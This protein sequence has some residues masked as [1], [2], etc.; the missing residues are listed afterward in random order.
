[1]TPKIRV[2]VIFGGTSTEHEVSLVSARSIIAALDPQK[3]SVLPVMITKDNRW[4]TPKAILADHTHVAYLPQT[5]EKGLT[6]KPQE[7]TAK[8]QIDVY[9]PVLH[10]PYGEDGTIQGLL[11]MMH[12]PYVGDG[13]LASA[14]CMDKD[15]QK[16]LCRE[17]GLPVIE[18]LAI[19]S[20]TEPIKINPPCFVKPANQG[21]SVG[22]TKVQ[23]QSELEAAIQQAFT[24]DTKVLIEKAVINPREIE[25]AVL[26]TTAKPEAS[27]LGE[28]ISSN[29]FYDYD[30]K[31]VDGKSK[32]IIPAKLTAKLTAAIQSAAKKAFTV[33]N[34]YGLARVDFLLDRAGEYYLS[35]LNTLPGFTTISMYPKLWAASGLSYPSLLDKLIELAIL[36]QHERA[37]LATTYTPKA[38]WYQPE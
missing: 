4:L 1:M 31:Y 15:I 26:G 20:P 3:Y 34:C 36:K 14:I 6:I 30:A 32:A 17:A 24:L 11:E 38:N 5:T 22:V 27:V 28:I 23:Q 9:F 37:G 25:C 18:Y 33:T 29:E 19:T 16:R 2:A 7:I 8:H 35:E 10:G 21:S 13:V 12:V